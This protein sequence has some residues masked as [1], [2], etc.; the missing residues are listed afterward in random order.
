MQKCGLLIMAMILG[1]IYPRTADA[2]L[3]GY[4]DFNEDPGLVA[5]DSSS[6]GNNGDLNSVGLSW[7]TGKYGTGLEFVGNPDGRV[8]VPDSNS[9]DLTNA[10]TIMAW[11]KPSDFNNTGNP[12]VVVS[13]YTHPN[14]MIFNLKT[15]NDSSGFWEFDATQANLWSQTAIQPDEWQHLAVTYDG[16]RMK[17]YFDGNL[18]DTV[19][20]IGN[21]NVDDNPVI[22]GGQNCTSNCRDPF[23]GVID[24]V[25]IYN[26][27]LAQAEIQRDMSF[28]S[29]IPEPSSMLLLGGGLLIGLVRKLRNRMI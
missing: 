9:L 3:V 29:T 26:N 14:S 20:A 7:I 1:L 6:F 13:K 19:D 17:L 24:E 2:I 27:A 28:N 12:L 25:R 21:L 16:T 15:A 8:V 4:W 10:F 18:E 11:V 23:R 5:H 22:I